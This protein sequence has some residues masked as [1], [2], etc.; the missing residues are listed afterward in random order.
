ML[1][2]ADAEAQ[3]PVK[4]GAVGGH[5]VHPLGP[6]HRRAGQQFGHKAPSQTLALVFARHHHIPEHGAEHAIAGG[7]A[8]AHQL[9]A[10]PGAHHRLTAREHGRQL[11]ALPAPG[12]ETVLIKQRLQGPQPPAQPQ[13]E[14]A[15][16]NQADRGGV[17]QGAGVPAGWSESSP[18]KRSCCRW[19]YWIALRRWP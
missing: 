14:A 16:A 11:A 4:A 12:P 17:A 1:G 15:M 5:Q 9:L 13:G 3:S 10:L 7:P 8:E 19:V 6:G 18:L 2:V